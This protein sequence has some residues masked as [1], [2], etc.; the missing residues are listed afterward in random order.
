M[1]LIL[2]LAIAHYYQLADYRE[3]KSRL[4]SH[5]AVLRRIR[6]KFKKE[7]KVVR[8]KNNKIEEE[9]IPD[10]MLNEIVQELK[11]RVPGGWTG[12]P[13]R[14]L[15]LVIKAP[16]VP[17]YAVQY[18]VWSAKWVVKYTVLGKEYDIADK[19]YLTRVNAGFTEFDWNQL[20]QKERE[21][22]MTQEVWRSSTSKRKKP[23]SSKKKA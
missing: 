17:L 4:M 12:E 14:V 23:K 7:G 6:I 15:D 22:Y 20:E 1:C 11:L 21:E 10:A 2:V 19:E 9:D 5:N 8:T 18:M 13:P 16:M 3:R